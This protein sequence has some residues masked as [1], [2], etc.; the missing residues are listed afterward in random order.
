[1]IRKGFRV[2]ADKPDIEKNRGAAE[3]VAGLRAK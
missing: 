3:S 2:W 1:M